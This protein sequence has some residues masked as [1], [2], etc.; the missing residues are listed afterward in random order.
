MRPP[1]RAGQVAHAALVPVGVHHDLLT[2]VRG[3]GIGHA[4]APLAVPRDLALLIVLIEAD[5]VLQVR[6]GRLRA[7]GEG[8]GA[9]LSQVPGVAR[10]QRPGEVVHQFNDVL[11]VVEVIDD[12][13]S[14]ILISP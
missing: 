12:H 14:H 11:D 10:G 2:G 3:R 7:A 4:G 5:Q 8:E 9:S 13:N 1:P 6:H